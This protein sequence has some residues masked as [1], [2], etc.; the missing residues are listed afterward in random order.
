MGYTS[1]AS[2]EQPINRPL[3]PNEAQARQTAGDGPAVDQYAP[4]QQRARPRH[5]GSRGGQ[6]H[7]PEARAAAGIAA[8]VRVRV[9][10]NARD[11][12][13]WRFLPARAVQRAVLAGE[14]TWAEMDPD[15]G[16]V[17]PVDRRPAGSNGAAVLMGAAAHA[18]AARRGL[19]ADGRRASVLRL[20]GGAW[21][22]RPD[23]TS[24]PAPDR[25]TMLGA[26][27]Q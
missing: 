17:V 11:R 3:P 24:G 9:F 18:V 19:A 14:A 20:A 23:P 27:Q 7:R 13:P 22:Y 21:A 26:P 5:R 1:A 15:S 6:K 8:E 16:A 12:W 10:A 2:T 25:G 4:V